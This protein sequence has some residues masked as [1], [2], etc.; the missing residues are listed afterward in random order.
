MRKI[1]IGNLLALTVLLVNSN[2]IAQKVGA[3]AG[4]NISRISYSGDGETIEM[5]KDN[6]AVLTSTTYG[7]Y[8]NYSIIPLLSLQVEGNYDPRGNKFDPDFYN[9]L[10]SLG[11]KKSYTDFA[12]DGEISDRLN[13]L[14]F[15]VMLKAKLAFFHV[16]AGPYLGF[17]LNAK[18]VI[19]GSATVS[20]QTMSIDEEADSKDYYK[21]TDFGIAAGA[22]VTF[23]LGPA[24]LMAGARY[25]MG[26]TN[27]LKEP[28][29]N[30]SSKHQ[31]IT[32]FA[33]VA[34]G[35]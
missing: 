15:P 8:L 18:Q 28:S 30:E 31:V 10:Y 23:N 32:L 20:G 7:I 22:G 14:T 3:K 1:L 11:S 19:K 12:F 26:M 21:S 4:I 9:Y 17:L 35:L 13:Y 16:E 25:M 5:I 24:Q 2:V 29:A 6:I 33:G 27:I 34:I